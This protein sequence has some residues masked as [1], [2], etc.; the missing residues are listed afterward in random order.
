MT[1]TNP[2]SWENPDQSKHKIEPRIEP[3]NHDVAMLPAAPLCHPV[4]PHVYVLSLQCSGHAY[5]EIMADF[6]ANFRQRNS[7]SCFLQ[8]AQPCVQLIPGQKLLQPL[9]G[10]HVVRHD[11]NHTGF[12]VGQRHTEH[13]KLVLLVL[14]EAINTCANADVSA[15]SFLADMKVTCH[16]SLFLFLQD[17]NIAVGM[18]SW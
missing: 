17:Y 13:E 3:Q 7:Y 9:Q 1:V 6:H 4:S 5:L 10:L 2:T 11:E 8:L 12:L 18:N 16:N 14:I 15:S